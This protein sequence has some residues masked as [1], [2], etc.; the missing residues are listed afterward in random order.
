MWNY[1]PDIQ[2][3]AF[4]F[5]KN[6]KFLPSSLWPGGLSTGNNDDDAR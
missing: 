4:K 1:I 6:V 2:E 5:M 3:Q